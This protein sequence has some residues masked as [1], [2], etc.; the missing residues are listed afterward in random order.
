MTPS[1]EGGIKRNFRQTRNTFETR[2]ASLTHE[3][4]I[5]NPRALCFWIILCSIQA[6]V[7]AISIVPAR[8][9][10]TESNG[11]VI[12]MLLILNDTARVT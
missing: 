4:E 3:L 8:S 5:E 2:W 7:I 11:V 1:H 12:L 10:E 6:V 9:P